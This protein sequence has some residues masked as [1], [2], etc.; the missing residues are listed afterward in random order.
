MGH[1]GRLHL[2]A[3]PGQRGG[4]GWIR[5][6]PNKFTENAVFWTQNRFLL[7]TEACTTYEVSCRGSRSPWGVGADNEEHRRC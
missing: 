5:T 2:E 4:Q 6:I 1:L 3:P 7:R